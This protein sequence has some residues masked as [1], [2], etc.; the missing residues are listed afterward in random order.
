MPSPT[1]FRLD[2]TQRLHHGR[3][4][5]RVFQ[6]IGSGQ[7]GWDTNRDDAEQLARCSTQEAAQRDADQSIARAGHVCDES[8]YAWREL[9]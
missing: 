4:V 6:L 1:E 8:C 5:V 3:L 9:T 7:F 2:R